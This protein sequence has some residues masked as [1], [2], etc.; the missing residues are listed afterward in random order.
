M[1]RELSGATDSYITPEEMIRPSAMSIALRLGYDISEVNAIKAEEIIKN[2]MLQPRED[3]MF[4]KGSF[5][6]RMR[7]PGAATDEQVRDAIKDFYGEMGFSIKNFS[8]TGKNRNS[9][10]IGATD[11]TG[12][13]TVNATNYPENG[14][15]RLTINFM[16]NIKMAHE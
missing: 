2:G 12:T 8:L 4:K 5:L 13:Y 11:G 16:P 7:R 10:D 3:G 6:L 9:I 14:E 1:Y 15:I